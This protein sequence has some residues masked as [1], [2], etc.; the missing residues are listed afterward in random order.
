MRA[1]SCNRS[2]RSL[3]A[4]KRNRGLLTSRNLDTAALHRG[5]TRYHGVNLAT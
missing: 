4:V 2:R 1:T 3:D 5:Y